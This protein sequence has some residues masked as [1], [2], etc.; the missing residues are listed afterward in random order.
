MPT[1]SAF[2][3]SSSGT[4]ESLGFDA[5]HRRDSAM[6]PESTASQITDLDLGGEL[7]EYVYVS[8]LLAGEI[9]VDQHIRGGQTAYD[10]GTGFWLGLDGTT[11]KFSLGDSAG[12]HVTW[13]GSTLS[14]VGTLSV[15]SDVGGWI[16]TAD[17]VYSLS[18]GTPTSSPNN[19]IVLDSSNPV[20]TVYEGTAKR[21]EMGYLSASVFGFRAYA[22][23]GTDVVFEASD[24]RQF[25]GGWTFDNTKLSSGS[26]SIN[27]STEQMLFGSATSPTVGTGIFIGLDSALYQFRVGD[28]AGNQM[29][30]T[31]SALD[32]IG[33]ISSRSTATI[34]AAIN[35]SGNLVTDLINVRLDTSAKTMLSGFTFGAADYSG[36]LSSGTITWNTTT[37]ALTG[38]SGVL[39][40]RGGII[41]AAAGV[42]TFTIDAA[43][44]A[45][46]FAGALS[47]P[48]GNIGGFTIGATS[49]SVV[50]GGNTVIV[51]SGAT[52]FTA[53]PT[54]SPTFTVTQAGVLTATGVVV[55][56]SVTATSGDIGG[57][58]V[59]SGYI[60]NLQSGTPTST[61]TDGIVLA[62]GNEALIVYEDAAERV[63]VGYLSSGVYGLRGFA[64][65]GTTT[66]FELSDTTQKIAGFTFTDTTIS[67][68]N[69]EIVS[70]A[71]NT[72]HIGVGTGSNFAG[73]NSP[74]AAGDLA[75]WAG[76]TFANRANAPMRLYA[77]G[78]GVTTATRVLPRDP[79]FQGNSAD[80]M[81][82]EVDAGG[83]ISR[84]I[85]ATSLSTGA[86]AGRAS[87]L[88]GN[89]GLLWASSPGDMDW[90]NDTWFSCQT[91]F[92]ST[93]TQDAFLGLGCRTDL[94]TP[95]VPDNATSTLRHIAFMLEDGTLYASNADGTT[96]TRTDVT[97]SL[98]ITKWN[99]YS[100]VYVAATS[101]QFWINGVLAA[102]HTTN[103]PSGA[104]DWEL[105]FGIEAQA[106]SAR[107]IQ[108]NNNY[109]V[110][111]R[112]N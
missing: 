77:D 22:T 110:S 46:T 108:V 13:D 18:S 88:H 63:R 23:N 57:W 85:A 78:S 35:S 55:S 16:I 83:T 34:A 97:G 81:I 6:F 49:L 92:D 106:S 19:G 82:A 52:A 99:T 25:V 31:G 66:I 68:T 47:A 10:T 101:I 87:T 5:Y 27:G 98:D 53:G 86:V 76:D 62:S 60:Y 9:S 67:A 24:T 40:Y 48:T 7:I 105:G 90:D 104:T 29:Y 42:A 41:G 79:F 71:A 4:L 11:A 65:D 100:I 8:S 112:Q 58:N 37:G 36:A 96:Q 26:V 70:G 69:V 94:T 84:G 73:I 1:V 95:E 12:D 102:T 32:L 45:A 89:D 44:G 17:T 64:T 59:V 43:T 111:M 80:G 3:S 14:I 33:T 39:V 72:A 21:V 74:N 61:P 103:I 28:P 50:N 56:G 15:G 75:F 91:R 38:G 54:G 2:G 30:W 20:I 109:F 93:T 51:S 107:N